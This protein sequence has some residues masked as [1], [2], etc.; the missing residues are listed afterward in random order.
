MSRYDDVSSAEAF[1]GST[2]GERRKNPL[3]IKSVGDHRANLYGTGSNWRGVVGTGNADGGIYP[4]FTNNAEGARAGI[5]N[6]WSKIHK[7]QHHN[8]LGGQMANTNALLAQAWTASAHHWNNYGKSIAASVGESVNTKI[9]FNN[10]TDIAKRFRA[11]EKVETGRNFVSDADLTTAVHDAY[12]Y[13]GD[14]YGINYNVSRE[15]AAKAVRE[16]SG[17]IPSSVRAAGP[18]GVTVNEPDQQQLDKWVGVLATLAGDDPEEVKKQLSSPATDDPNTPEDKAHKL[19]FGKVAKYAKDKQPII[20]EKLKDENFSKLTNKEVGALKEF[21]EYMDYYGGDQRL[22]EGLTKEGDFDEKIFDL[23]KQIEALQTSPNRTSAQDQALENF[24]K[25]RDDLTK[26]RDALIRANVQ[27][28]SK[29]YAQDNGGN[30]SLGDM[31]IGAIIMMIAELFGIGQYVAPFLQ[32]M[33]MPT[34]GYGPGGSPGAGNWGREGSYN[35]PAASELKYSLPKGALG[36]EKEIPENSQTDGRYRVMLVKTAGDKYS[37]YGEMVLVNPQGE[38]EARYNVHSGGA[39]KGALPGMSADTGEAVTAMYNLNWSDIRLNRGDRIGR[40]GMHYADGSLGY[41]FTIE[42]PS[43]MAE[44]G[45][46]GRNLFRIHP[47]G[48]TVKSLGCVEFLDDEGKLSTERQK[49]D[50]SSDAAAKHFLARMLELSKDKGTRPLG[51]EVVNG[52]H[53]KEK[54][55]EI[56]PEKAPAVP[57]TPEDGR[58]LRKA[59]KDALGDYKPVSYT[60]ADQ[61]RL[62]HLAA[63]AGDLP[64]EIQYAVA[65]VGGVHDEQSKAE[66]SRLLIQMLEDIEKRKDHGIFYSGAKEPASSKTGTTKEQAAN[67]AIPARLAVQDAQTAT[68]ATDADLHKAVA[69]LKSANDEKASAKS[70]A[71]ISA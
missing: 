47:G 15:D 6:M 60:S 59:M 62:H 10:V 24:K 46:A 11:M 7:P 23:N 21:L 29:N 36:S 49:G 64:A 39:G 25:Q 48:K 28:A 69:Q 57:T 35:G 45:G 4:T 53:L 13:L 38:V 22:A 31:V 26:D 33:G 51:L 18:S 68:S 71:S 44:I 32:G 12:K 63:T 16:A 1:S 70:S 55:I 52:K 58:T 50:K 37:A 61:A 66:Q 40:A 42:N 2:L 41:S 27:A 3:N 56:A 19:S 20:D 8:G 5:I 65:G 17:G 67:A 43:N 34:P 14:K 30:M 9:D 54:G